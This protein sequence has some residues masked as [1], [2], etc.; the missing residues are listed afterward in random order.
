M[1]AGEDDDHVYL[2]STSGTPADP[3]VRITLVPVSAALRFDLGRDVDRVF[4]TGGGGGRGRHYLSVGASINAV[5]QTA[6]VLWSRGELNASFAGSAAAA[7]R[8]P[9]PAPF[10]RTASRID[11]SHQPP[12]AFPLPAGR[13]TG[14][15][16]P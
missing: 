3:A 10:R 13:P 11:T 2:E 9:L 14:P 1:A 12:P 4:G 16:P 5:N 7:L 8:P 15:T 6:A